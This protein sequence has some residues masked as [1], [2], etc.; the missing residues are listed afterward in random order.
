[1][2]WAGSVW[3]VSGEGEGFGDG[4]Y[5]GVEGGGGAIEGASVFV[6]EALA[7]HG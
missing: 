5:G 6:V 3:S 7:F 2:G 4:V 1:M